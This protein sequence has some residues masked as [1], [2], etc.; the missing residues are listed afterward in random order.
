MG[1][2]RLVTAWV[3]ADPQLLSWWWPGSRCWSRPQVSHVL[4]NEQRGIFYLRRTNK[5]PPRHLAPH[6][7]LIS[8]W[9]LVAADWDSA[10]PW[11]RRFCSGR[12]TP[13]FAARRSGCEGGARARPC[14]SRGYI[15]PLCRGSSHVPSSYITNITIAACYLLSV[16]F[17]RPQTVSVHLHHW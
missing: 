10:G 14:C 16:W 3:A 6:P 15:W 12:A 5:P 17:Q 9:H 1:H 7:Q 4:A 8:I 2:P 13:P 11:P